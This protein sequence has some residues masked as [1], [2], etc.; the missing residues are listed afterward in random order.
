MVD[1]RDYESPESFSRDSDLKLG[2]SVAPRR[3][4]A[5]MPPEVTE[6]I[7]VRLAQLGGARFLGDQ[8]DSTLVPIDRLPVQR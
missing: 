5:Q 3:P 1:L 6:I 2:K 8:S 7:Q 4:R